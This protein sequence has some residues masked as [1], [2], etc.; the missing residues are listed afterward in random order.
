MEKV[1][2]NTSGIVKRIQGPG[3]DEEKWQEKLWTK[4][5]DI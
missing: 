5:R 1:M 3:R 4:V 2:K